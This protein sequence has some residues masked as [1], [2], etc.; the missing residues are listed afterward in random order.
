MNT[1]ELLDIGRTIKIQSSDEWLI[2][3]QALLAC[4][5][6]K[7]LY[8]PDKY[9]LLF[10]NPIAVVRVGIIYFMGN[11]DIHMVTFPEHRDEGY[12]SRFVKSG[13]IGK[14]EPALKG[15]RIVA[16]EENEKAAAEHLMA[17]AGLRV[18][19]SEEKQQQFL[20]SLAE[21]GESRN[22]PKCKAQKSYPDV[23]KC[24]KCGVKFV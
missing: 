17:L 2:A 24:W 9:V 7:S 12:M 1:Q 8:V 6:T 11:Y 14:I 5:L 23:K 21:T 19:T 3:G 20:D 10:N 13:L 15:S 4:R 18:F 16:T 22:C